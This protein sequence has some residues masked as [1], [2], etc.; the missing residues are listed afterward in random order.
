MSFRTY[1]DKTVIPTLNK[2]SRFWGTLKPYVNIKLQINGRHIVQR[3][4]MGNS[5]ICSYE[6]LCYLTSAM[7]FCNITYKRKSTTKY[8]DWLSRVKDEV[9]L[10]SYIRQVNTMSI[11]IL[12]FV[13]LLLPVKQRNVDLE[14][15]TGLQYIE[16]R[17]Q[18][19]N[20]EI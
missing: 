10:Y 2:D 3:P 17:F 4:G 1:T 20:N 14:T 5:W 19:G 15:H 13:L 9:M 8:A 16:W 11:I 7:V 12:T 18:W 6:L